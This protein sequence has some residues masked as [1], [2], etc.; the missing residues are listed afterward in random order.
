METRNALCSCEARTD[1]LRRVAV[2]FG[3]GS[4]GLVFSGPRCEDQGQNPSSQSRPR[5]PMQ[6]LKFSIALTVV[7][8][9]DGIDKLLDY[10]ITC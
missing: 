4:G 8:R 5:G 2:I 1:F 7:V 3:K 6:D 9:G 10:D